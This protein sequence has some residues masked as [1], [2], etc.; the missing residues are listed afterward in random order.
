MPYVQGRV[1]RYDGFVASV[2]CALGQKPFPMR[3]KVRSRELKFQV[4]FAASEERH[5]RFEWHKIGEQT[6]Q[7]SRDLLSSFGCAGASQRAE[8]KHQDR[9]VEQQR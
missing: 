1:D 3:C 7:L 6:Q 4:V 5:S 9:C 8:E 2:E